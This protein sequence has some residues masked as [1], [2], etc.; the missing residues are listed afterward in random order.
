MNGADARNIILQLTLSLFSLFVDG[1]NYQIFVQMLETALTCLLEGRHVSEKLH[2]ESSTNGASDVSAK[3]WS[4]L[5]ML[6]KKMLAS[7]LLAGPNKTAVASQAT[8]SAKRYGD[9]EKLKELYKLSLK[10]PDF[11]QLQYMNNIW[12]GTVVQDH[13]T[14]LTGSDKVTEGSE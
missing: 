2:S 4:Q 9:A 5:Q 14:N 8:S 12:A 3:F 7:S 6:L 11:C 1:A 10:S 13:K